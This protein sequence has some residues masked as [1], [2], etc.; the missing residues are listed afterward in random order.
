[1]KSFLLG[2]LGSVALCIPSL[3][4][5]TSQGV[6]YQES[7]NRHGVKLTSTKEVIYLG[8]SCDVYSPQLGYGTWGQANGGLLVTFYNGVTRGFPKQNVYINGCK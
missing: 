2:L 4:L 7:Y 3:A 5:G 6:Y 1:M 8:K